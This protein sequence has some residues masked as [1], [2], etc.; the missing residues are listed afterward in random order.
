M[1]GT[2]E[3]YDDLGS[4]FRD[5]GLQRG[6]ADTDCRRVGTFGN[7]ATL[8]QKPGLRGVPA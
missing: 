2:M 3:A 1:D 8:A 4:L 7:V 6:C 5:Q